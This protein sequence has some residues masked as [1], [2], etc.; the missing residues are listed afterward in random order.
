MIKLLL[1]LQRETSSIVASHAFTLFF[2][3]MTDP[4][5]GFSP[6]I[7]NKS[8]TIDFS[9]KENTSSKD[10]I[11]DLISSSKGGRMDIIESNSSNEVTY[12]SRKRYSVLANAAIRVFLVHDKFLLQPFDYDRSGLQEHVWW[13][14][15][16]NYPQSV[17]K[18]GLEYERL[19]GGSS[20]HKEYISNPDPPILAELPTVYIMVPHT[21]VK[22]T[23]LSPKLNSKGIELLGL[24][25]S[26][27]GRK[28]VKGLFPW[29]SGKIPSFKLYLIAR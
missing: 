8:Q 4:I 26:T 25:G 10:S 17:H 2:C 22:C 6:P 9:M 5:D 3:Q 19:R 24:F 7:P 23:T 29:I 28:F 14:G 27:R 13:E 16:I 15:Q 20:R 12:T 18:R 1:N 11:T 21:L